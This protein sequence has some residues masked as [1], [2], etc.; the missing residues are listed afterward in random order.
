MREIRQFGTYRLHPERRELERTGGGVVSL[1][2]KAFDALVLLVEHAGEPV[3]RK[4]LMDALWPDTIVEENNLT[5]AVSALRRALGEG[6]IV[7]LPGR[8][9]QFVAEVKG[10]GPGVSGEDVGSGAA[11]ES[12]DSNEGAASEPPARDFGRPLRAAVA[13]L[14]V[15]ALVVAAGYLWLVP[16]EG[17]P[18]IAVLPFVNVSSDPAQEY[19]AD[20]LSD[21]LRN[22]LAR[23]KGLRVA[24]RTSSFAFKG[25]NASLREI[26]EALNVDTVVGGTVRRSADRLRISVELVNVAD[27]YTLWSS[28]VY[29]PELDDVFAIQ[30]EIARAV[31]NELSPMLGVGAP[32]PNYGG[33]KS[34][35]AYDHFLRG[36]TQQAQFIPPALSNAAEEFRR[37]VAIDPSYGHAW[38]ELGFTLSQL[39]I[40]SPARSEQLLRERA[41]AAQR[42][43][44][45]APALPMTQVI[46]GWI[47][48]DR[49]DWEASIANCS[50]IFDETGDPRA[51]NI[52]SGALTGFGFVR[53]ALPYREAAARADPLAMGV[54]VTLA[55][56]Y[57]LM[58]ISAAVVREYER[59][60]QFP[61]DS[62]GREEPMLFSLMH[63][64]AAP[65]QL[66]GR[67]AHICAGIPAADF[68]AD[69]LEAV[70]TP[71]EAP[72]ILRG[73]LER[74]R[75][76]VPQNSYIVALFAAYLE[77]PDL[78]LDALEI[79][80]RAAPPALYQHFWYPLLKDARADPRFNNLMREIGFAD[81][82]QKTGRWNDYCRPAGR[83]DFECT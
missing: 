38:A 83:N 4:A 79:F 8:G 43:R 47:A 27:G 54:S 50:R 67:L 37:A 5:Q 58:G 19:F 15:A 70:S 20:G 25:G 72:R 41:E 3:S 39:A 29:E 12:V 66:A 53:D 1:G 21:E 10:C 51:H 32:D 14:A 52:C 78:A 42:A 33:T 36:L 16:R 49:R 2:A 17:E 76:T 40:F 26:G 81:W 73:L 13:A 80:A 64:G 34:F 22:R 6:Y 18:S 63:E 69:L 48:H 62:W 45:V 44:D 59:S 82:W 57:A 7:T 23:L 31:V 30:D 46:L 28:G 65:E 68:C 11:S 9:Y 60:A 61:G 74:L 55:R 71:D 56:H 77:H 75:P 24:A 35:E